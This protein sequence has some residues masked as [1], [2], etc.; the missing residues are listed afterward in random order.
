LT[1]QRRSTTK[2]TAEIKQLSLATV[3]ET[4]QHDEDGGLMNEVNH[5][6]VQDTDKHWWPQAEALVGLV[7]AWQLSA[8]DKYLEA[9]IR[10]WR[11]II[12]TC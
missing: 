4:F 5:K 12:K 7:N 6:G 2:V 1:P 10:N 3:E 9:A 8:D 11:F